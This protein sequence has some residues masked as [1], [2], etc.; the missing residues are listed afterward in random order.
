[1]S[2]RFNT[3]ELTSWSVLLLAYSLLDWAL[4]TSAEE[5]KSGDFLL[6]MFS[7]VPL[8]LHPVPSQ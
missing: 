7:V 4:R 2:L 8:V 1:M 3:M 5:G 6:I